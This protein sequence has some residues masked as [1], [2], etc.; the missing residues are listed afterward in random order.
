MERRNYP[1][2]HTRFPAEV[3]G[4][5]KRA[6]DHALAADVS[7]TGLQLV[8]DA[9]VAGRLVPDA[10]RADLSSAKPVTVRVTLPLRDGTHVKVEARC[11]LR[12][13]RRSEDGEYRIG[14][15]Y[16]YFEGQSY[17]ALEAFIDDW[18]SY[19]DEG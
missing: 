13:V 6:T 3:I 2:L 9:R 18:V 11:K 19:P 4:G 1:R 10:E 16:D 7:I 12:M 5:G 8:C 17:N 15:E 14:L